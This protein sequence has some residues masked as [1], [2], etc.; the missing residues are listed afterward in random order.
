ML[1]HYLNAST[2]WFQC[3]K[4][5]HFQNVAQLFI[6][7][8]SDENSHFHCKEP[9]VLS[10]LPLLLWIEQDTMAYIMQGK[11][12]R[13]MYSMELKPSYTKNPRWFIFE[14]RWKPTSIHEYF[15]SSVTPCTTT[16]SKIARTEVPRALVPN[17]DHKDTE[18]MKWTY[19]HSTGL[20]GLP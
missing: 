14:D 18:T 7:T 10:G 17:G 19:L 20:S 12:K 9:I 11:L 15:T 2:R 3:A 5:F 6:G 4:W 8:S 13:S 1:I 16:I